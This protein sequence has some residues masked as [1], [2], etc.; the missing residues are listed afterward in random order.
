MR[1]N[2]DTLRRSPRRLAEFLVPLGYSR[3]RIT[4]AL[5]VQVGVEPKTAKK[6][7]E[8]VA[9]YAGVAHPTSL[10]GV[11][12]LEREQDL[13]RAVAAEHFII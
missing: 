9:A 5:V 8:D 11:A 3:P 12:R 13:D 10:A 4:R 7:H 6:L 2:P 1:R